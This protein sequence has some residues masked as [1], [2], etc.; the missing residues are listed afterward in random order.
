VYAPSWQNA[1]LTQLSG[2]VGVPQLGINYTIGDFSGAL[3]GSGSFGASGV[4]LMP[5]LTSNNLGV[6]NNYADLR[7]DPDQTDEKDWITFSITLTDDT[8]SSNT[9]TQAPGS[10]PGNFYLGINPTPTSGEFNLSASVQSGGED[11]ESSPAQ[12]QWSISGSTASPS[13]GDLADGNSTDITLDTS[14]NN[15]SYVLTASAGNDPTLSGTATVDIDV[16]HLDDIKATM[17][18]QDGQSQ[19]Q[20]STD[21]SLTITDANVSA[22]PENQSAQMEFQ[23]EA[24][25]PNSQ[26]DLSKLSWAVERNPT[27]NPALGTSAPA[28]AEVGSNPSSQ[29]VDINLPG[30]FNIIAY[31]DLAGTGQWQQDEILRVFHLAIIGV[32]APNVTA[33]APGG[34]QVTTDYGNNTVTFVSGSSAYVDAEGQIVPYS[35]FE[36]SGA[37]KAVGGGPDETIGVDQISIG[38]LQNLTSF[39][40][41]LTYGTGNNTGVGALT[42]DGY[43]APVLDAN[44]GQTTFG[45][46]AD[47]LG[48][49]G[50]QS[51]VP[52]ATGGT[53]SIN[54]L[55][56]PKLSLD[57]EHTFTI[58]G[59]PQT[60]QAEVLSGSWRF[61]D[62]LVAYS[63]SFDAFYSAYAEVDWEVDWG[64]TAAWNGSTVTWDISTQTVVD[65]VFQVF[66]GG[67]PGVTYGPSA[68]E[69]IVQP[70]ALYYFP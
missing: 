39:A 24:V 36:N 34:S 28:I 61:A 47:D 15:Y 22:I 58:N 57:I 48:A 9:L 7:S 30:S 27:D 54:D 63:S 69:L 4:L 14:S 5:S 23:A 6:N 70:G 43:S 8:V 18:G 64:A 60:L 17:V 37:V 45:E 11:Y 56:E 53:A 26:S 29:D 32:S 55:D 12:V 65:N 16:I 67:S 10:T 21:T 20:I 3:T 50:A 46:G 68:D 44:Y 33:S 1:M 25:V 38:W 49:F 59:A 31:A 52:G 40:D 62:R 13:S 2:S 35:V 42:L 19:S 41:Q 66:G 51:V